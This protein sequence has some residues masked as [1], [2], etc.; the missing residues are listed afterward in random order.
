M[1][2]PYAGTLGTQ[3]YRWRSISL[4]VLDGGERTPE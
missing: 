4:G 2:R 1:V 3:V